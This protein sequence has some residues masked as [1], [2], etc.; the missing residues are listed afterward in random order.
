MP[1]VSFVRRLP[2]RDCRL[3]SLKGTPEMDEG[4]GRAP[5]L[6][7]D[8]LARLRAELESL[9]GIAGLPRPR[10]E[11]FLAAVTSA[12]HAYLADRG[13]APGTRSHE[14]A[15][16][17]LDAASAGRA[18]LGALEAL[19]GPGWGLVG[20]KL[21][22]LAGGEEDPLGALDAAGMF[23]CVRR[24]ST[25]VDRAAET[26]EREPQIGLD[27]LHLRLA[28][29]VGKA[30]EVVGI[31]LTPSPDGPFLACLNAAL[32]VLGGTREEPPEV[33]LERA[34]KVVQRERAGGSP[35]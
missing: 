22:H 34:A 25:A 30:L 9:P 31:P 19:D 29:S 27:R 21:R 5:E 23:A 8:A 32:G 26:A 14:V 24:F 18:L 33:L 6:T 16:R 12:C 13:V 2:P 20:R 4:P 11:A 15:N 1:P 10:A 35:S 28:V 7:Q 3:R 17:L